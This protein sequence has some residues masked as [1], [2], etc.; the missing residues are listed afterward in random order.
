MNNPVKYN[1]PSGHIPGNAGKDICL[2]GE[3]CFDP[4]TG[5]SISE[6]IT[7]VELNTEDN[8]R[9]RLEELG[10]RIANAIESRHPERAINEVIQYAINEFNMSKYLKYI[11]GGVSFDPN[12][13]ENT[14]GQTDSS[15]IENG[16][17]SVTI[18]P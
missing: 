8:R 5:D 17:V 1:D 15:N 13:P 9:K 12:M 4:E 18:G 11:T 16:V 7:L 3:Q 6:T 10:R 14:Y 2:D